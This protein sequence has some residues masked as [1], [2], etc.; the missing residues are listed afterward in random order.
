MDLDFAC[1]RPFDLLPSLLPPGRAVFGVGM[2]PDVLSSTGRAARVHRSQPWSNA[3]MAAPPRHP[4]FA[5][6]VGQLVSAARHK[7]VLKAT[8][9]RMLSAAIRQWQHMHGDGGLSLQPFGTIYN[10]D[11]LRRAAH[12]CGMGHPSELPSC[13]RRF[14]HSLATTFWTASW[15]NPSARTNTTST[16]KSRPQPRARMRSTK[17]RVKGKS[18]GEI[19]RG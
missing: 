1:L 13:A 12:P 4:F 2:P 9:P 3:F 10:H 18:V 19:T 15:I 5:F 11:G 8:G 16:G 6:L 14:P 7:S 17:T